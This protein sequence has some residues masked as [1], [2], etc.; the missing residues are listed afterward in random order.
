MA[1]SAA[2][3]GT[4]RFS[5][6]TRQSWVGGVRQLQVVKDA[7]TGGPNDGDLRAVRLPRGPRPLRRP[8]QEARGRVEASAQ[9]ATVVGITEDKRRAILG[10]PVGGSRESKTRSPY[11]TQSDSKSPE[12]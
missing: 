1:T 8:P 3:L 2:P 6:T 7:E 4:L 11:R 12:R 5:R 9:Q 10:K